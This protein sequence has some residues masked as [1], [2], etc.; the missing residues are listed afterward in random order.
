MKKQSRLSRTPNPTAKSAAVERIFAGC[1]NRV[2][3]SDLIV[4]LALNH[5]IT[6]DNVPVDLL[7]CLW[8]LAVVAELRN[9]RIVDDFAGLRE[10]LR[11]QYNEPA[12]GFWHPEGFL[13][14]ALANDMMEM[15]QLADAPDAGYIFV[16][17]ERLTSETA[18]QQMFP[19]ENGR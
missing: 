14:S 2:A 1:R 9:T 13:V 12:P 11:F 5:R 19:Q 3:V 16:A 7:P 6:I 4:C 15:E 8:L 17:Y 18:Y 10:R